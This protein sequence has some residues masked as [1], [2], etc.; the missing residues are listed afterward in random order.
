M[1]IAVIGGTGTVGRHVVARLRADGHQ[2]R[3]LSRKSS[4]YRADLTTGEGLDRALAGVEVVVDASND[5]S[6]AKQAAA[7]L[8]DGSRRLLAAEAA[9]GVRHHVCVSIVGCDH[10]PMGY[11]QA[12]ARQEELV[13]AGPVPW[14]I[15]RS[16]QFHEYVAAMLAGAARTGVLPLLSVPVQPI[17][18]EQ[19]AGA[20]ADAAAKPPAGRFDVAGPDIVNLRDVTRTWREVTGRRALAVPVPLP[21]RLGRAL[22]SGVLTQPAPRVRGTVGF[23]G[24]LREAGRP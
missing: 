14:T 5:Q 21:G 9:A 12:K 2:V 13:A 11:F 24:W 3:V 10:V 20:V 4:E 17:A 19:A 23:A 22:R 7:L 6:S 1:D 18:A 16:T 15:V 8:V